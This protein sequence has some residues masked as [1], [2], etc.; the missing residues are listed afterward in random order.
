MLAQSGPMGAAALSARGSSSQSR[1]PPACVPHV[2][3]FNLAPDP[4]RHPG[5]SL[6]NPGMRLFHIDTACVRALARSTWAASSLPWPS[7]ASPH[8]NPALRQPN[9]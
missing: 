8:G 1:L 9:N 5:H 4:P 2:P 7:C 3:P 6:L